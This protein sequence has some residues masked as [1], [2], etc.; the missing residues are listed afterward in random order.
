[1]WLSVYLLL[2]ILINMSIKKDGSLNLLFSWRKGISYWKMNILGLID[3]LFEIKNSKIIKITH[4]QFYKLA[5]VWKGKVR[6]FR[7]N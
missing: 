7:R 3:G 5:P 4:V 1:M 6:G 2:F